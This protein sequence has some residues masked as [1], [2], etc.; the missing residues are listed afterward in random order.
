MLR[1]L[2]TEL[3][4]NLD[5]S[6]LYNDPLQGPSL[7]AALRKWIDD[8]NEIQHTIDTEW[9]HKDLGSQAEIDELREALADAESRI[10][11]AKEIL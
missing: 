5:R 9:E 3:E 10:S 4:C 2:I 11:Q 1:N 8:L 6:T 7:D